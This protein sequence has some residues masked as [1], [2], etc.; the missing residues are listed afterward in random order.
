MEI[1]QISA[2]VSG[3]TAHLHNDIRDYYSFPGNISKQLIEGDIKN[4]RDSLDI[5]EQELQKFNV[6][7]VDKEQKEQH[8]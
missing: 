8:G 1:P 4:I 7:I 6:S 3:W 5:L 2:L